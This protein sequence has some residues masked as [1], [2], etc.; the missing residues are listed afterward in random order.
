M[1]LCIATPYPGTELRQLVEN[2]GLKTSTEWELYDT[3]TPVFENTLLSDEE[4]R[5]IKKKFLQQDNG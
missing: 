5:E 3:V 2:I 4:I 1:Y